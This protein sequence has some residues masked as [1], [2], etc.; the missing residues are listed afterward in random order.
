MFFPPAADPSPAAA[1]AAPE[2]QPGHPPKKTPEKKTS[3]DD[4]VIERENTSIS[5]SKKRS[6][7]GGVHTVTTATHGKRPK[8]EPGSGRDRSSSRRPSADSITKAGRLIYSAALQ[9]QQPLGAPRLMARMPTQARTHTQTRLRP[10]T[11]THT[12]NESLFCWRGKRKKKS[13]DFRSVCSRNQTSSCISRRLLCCL[14]KL[15]R[16]GEK[17]Q[18]L[19]L[20]EGLCGFRRKKKNCSYLGGEENIMLTY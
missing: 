6:P 2:T 20:A 16:K 3:S 15:R 5:I 17:T 9:Q 14:D 4:D 10:R 7:A 13:I 12:R 8:P 11:H 1:A 19:R 18:R